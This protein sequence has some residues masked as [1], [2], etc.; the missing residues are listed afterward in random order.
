MRIASMGQCCWQMPHPTQRLLSKS[1]AYTLIS[2][3]KRGN[4]IRN[5]PGVQSFTQIWQA[6]H[7]SLSMIGFG[8]SLRF[9]G[10]HSFPALSVI[11]PF[12]QILPQTPHS[13]Q[14]FSL[15]EWRAF[16]SPLIAKTGQFFA[17]AVQPVQASLMLYDMLLSHFLAAAAACAGI[18]NFSITERNRALL[19]TTGTG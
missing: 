16:L 15:M 7:I 5:A 3:R 6:L 1:S 2:P 11:A 19:Y 9:T 12:M 4:V 13:T 18:L 10:E 17:Q 8:H 14:R